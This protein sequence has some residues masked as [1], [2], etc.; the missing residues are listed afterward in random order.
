MCKM[1]NYFY[2]FAIIYLLKYTRMFNIPIDMYYVYVYYYNLFM[3]IS[4]TK[5]R[6]PLSSKKQVLEEII[7]ETRII[8]R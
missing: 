8:L 5:L 4:M 2:Y 3:H 6:K 7:V 1:Q